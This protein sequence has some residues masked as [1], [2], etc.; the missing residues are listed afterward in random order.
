M[1]S[2]HTHRYQPGLSQHELDRILSDPKIVAWLK[3]PRAINR[4]FELPYL[5]GYSQDG[6]TVYFDRRVPIAAIKIGR[7]FVNVLPF[8]ITHETVEKALIDL[9]GYKYQAAHEVATEA[10]HRKVRAA[11]RDIKAYEAAL[12]P[13]ID[14]TEVYTNVPPDLD[15]TPYIETKDTKNLTHIRKL[16]AP[17]NWSRAIKLGKSNG[18]LRNQAA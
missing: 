15:L 2:G 1:S 9:Y 17:A 11:G 13:W 10:E 12:K 6:R 18:H 3:Q 7:L 4:S 5:G 14:S 8:L 16:M